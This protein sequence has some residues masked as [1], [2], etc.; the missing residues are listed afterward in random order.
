MLRATAVQR[1]NDEL[2]FR[3]DGHSLE[4]K[5]IL[6]LMEAQRDLEHGKTLPRFL[7]QE[8][9]PLVLLANAHSVAKPIGFLRED[10]E[11]PIHYFA[12]N[13]DMPTFLARRFYK[14][15]ALANLRVDSP[16]S[17]PSV[18]VMRKDTV[19]FVVVADRQYDFV[20]N[21]YKADATLETNIENNWLLYGSDWLIGEAGLRIAK[22]L[23]D[24]NAVQA[25]TDLVRSGRAAVFGDLLADETAGGPLVMGANL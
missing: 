22:P 24:Q 21:Y 12:V 7:L 2:G 20:W 6:R 5:I 3:P 16:P 1:I 25:F 15:A 8:D 23:R 19:D 18:Y 4:T 10:D 14:D 13:S 9:Q 11:N 17:A